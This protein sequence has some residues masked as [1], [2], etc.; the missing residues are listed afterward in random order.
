[1]VF[2]RSGKQVHGDGACT[3]ASVFSSVLGSEQSSTSM[4]IDW[5]RCFQSTG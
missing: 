3:Q 2:K 1:M 4:R 5:K